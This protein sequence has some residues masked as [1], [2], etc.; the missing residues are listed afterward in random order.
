MTEK[1]RAAALRRTETNRVDAENGRKK[2]ETKK[3]GRLKMDAPN[4]TGAVRR[5]M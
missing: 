3:D 4:K 1:E 5:R 2:K